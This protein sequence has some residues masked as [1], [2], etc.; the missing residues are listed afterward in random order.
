MRRTI[1]LGGTLLVVLVVYFNVEQ[2]RPPDPAEVVPLLADASL[3]RGRLVWDNYCSGCHADDG[4]APFLPRDL[5]DMLAQRGFAATCEYVIESVVAPA[6]LVRKDYFLGV[7]RVGHMTA[8]QVADVT[9]WV[10][11]GIHR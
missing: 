8:R 3:E 6:K 2:L 7:M 5:A 9:L 11:A 1:A 10:M 4:R